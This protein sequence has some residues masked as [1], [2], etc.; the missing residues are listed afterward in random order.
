MNNWHLI[1]QQLRSNHEKISI[2]N[3]AQIMDDAF[4]IAR[5]GQLVYGVPFE[6]SRYLRLEKEFTPWKSSLAALRYLD[7][8]LYETPAKKNFRVR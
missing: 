3:R 8:M 4:N 1:S 5:T 2:L 7:A 6:L